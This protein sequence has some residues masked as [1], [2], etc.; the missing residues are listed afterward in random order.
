MI[1]APD[2]V[3]AIEAQ[4]VEEY[5]HEACGVIMGRGDERRLLR[6]RNAYD[7]KHAEDPTNFPRDART[8]YYLADA[9]RLAMVRLER[10]GWT[11]VVIYHSHVD[12]GAYFS[13][14]DKR[15]ALFNGEPHYPDAT[16]VV[17]SVVARAVAAMNGFRWDPARRDFVP[18]EL[19][20]LRGQDRAGQ[21]GA[22][23]T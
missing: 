10:D 17:V 2:E 3:Q 6:C 9:D 18:L 22:R 8:A 5:P 19:T 4:A 20:N 15:Q 7:D 16:Y 21:A 11:P 13:E 23:T 12:V 1:L 14:T